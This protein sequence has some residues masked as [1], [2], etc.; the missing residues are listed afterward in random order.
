MRGI[1][2]SLP[3]WG[4]AHVALWSRYALPAM[5]APGNLPAI[6]RIAPTTVLIYTN[7]MDRNVIEALP[8]FNDL[9]DVCAVSFVIIGVDANEMVELLH[10]QARHGGTCYKNCQNM[11]IKRAWE[12]DCGNVFMTADT[13]WSNNGAA[14]IEEALAAEKR[15]LVHVGYC[16]GGRALTANP[17]ALGRE[18]AAWAAD[19]TP[20]EM[21]RRFLRAS[22]GGALPPSITEPKFGRN[23]SNL[24]WSTGDGRGMMVRPIHLNLSFAYPQMGPIAM[25]HGVDHDFANRAFTS[26]DQLMLIQDTTEFM[27]LSIDTLGDSAPVYDPGQEPDYPDYSPELVAAYMKDSAS[28]W[29]REWMR[30]YWWCHDGTL[31]LDDPDRQRVERESDLAVDEMF[32]CY[33]RAATIAFWAN[34]RQQGLPMTHRTEVGHKKHS[35]TMRARHQ[36]GR[37]RPNR[38]AVIGREVG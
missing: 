29:Q 30:D 12:D 11:A 34:R 31:A 5:L 25:N 19:A 32:A 7:A 8:E 36:L 23:P 4:G 10:P 13:I 6:S 17:D 3:I 37:S 2:A 1:Y 21:S 20:L 33:N 38:S 15:G 26:R 28:P 35:A 22:G 18:M 16:T 14:K 27:V 9:M 24:R